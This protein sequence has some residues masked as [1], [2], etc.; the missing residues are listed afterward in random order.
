[1]KPHVRKLFLLPTALVFL[2]LAVSPAKAGVFLT[3]EAAFVAAIQPGYYLEDFNGFTGGSPLN[4]QTNYT[5]PGGQG[6]GWTAYAS[7][8]DGLYSLSNAL[9]V[10]VENDSLTITFT[11]NP[12]TAVGGLVADTDYFGNLFAGTVSITT[13]DGS[14]NSIVFAAAAQGFLGYSSTTPISSITLSAN[15]FI[16]V[17]HFYTGTR[18]SVSSPP[19]KISPSA[20][21]VVLSWPTNAAGLAFTLQSTTNLVSSTSWTTVSPAAFVTNGQNV[22]TNSVSGSQKFYRLSQ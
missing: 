10:N 22:V 5:A 11:K 13:S 2:A 14:S 20:A 6:F 8:N 18:V 4:G 15:G 7:N 17:R 21:T 19:L 16:A 3:N 12:V 9:S 1:M